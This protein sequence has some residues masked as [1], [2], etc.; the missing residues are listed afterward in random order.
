MAVPMAVLCLLR[1]YTHSFVHTCSRR[2]ILETYHD[3]ANIP[4]IA[5][6]DLLDIETSVDNTDIAIPE[7]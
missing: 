7:S 6:D 5:S 4:T 2:T 3:L 1:K